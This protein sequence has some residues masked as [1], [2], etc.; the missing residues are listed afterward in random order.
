MLHTLYLA[1]L[2]HMMD[3]IKGFLKKQ[4]RLDAFDKVWKTLPP[5]HGFLVPKK[6]YSEVTQ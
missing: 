5:Y 1:I 4:E 3:W 2:N 6:G